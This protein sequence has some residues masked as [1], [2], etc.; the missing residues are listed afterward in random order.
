MNSLILALDNGQFHDPA[1]SS[2]LFDAYRMVGVV[3]ARTDVDALGKKRI[4]F[5][6][7]EQSHDHSVYQPVA[8][9]LLTTTLHISVYRSMGDLRNSPYRKVSITE[10]RGFIIACS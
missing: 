7:R 4:S 8:L 5:S 2:P 6:C 10:P 1:P 3:G 9:S